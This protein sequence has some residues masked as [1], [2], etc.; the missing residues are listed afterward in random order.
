M[1]MVKANSVNYERLEK[2]Y[3]RLNK[4]QESFC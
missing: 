4:R 2:K 3:G 1:N